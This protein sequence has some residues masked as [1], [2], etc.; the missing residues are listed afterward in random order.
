MN[1]RNPYQPPGAPVEDIVTLSGSEPPFFAVGTGKLLLMVIATSNLYSLYW[2]YR[3]WKTVERHEAQR[4]FP[5]LRTFLGALVL[6]PLFRRIAD[7]QRACKL[8]P[9]LMA[10][11]WAVALLVTTMI[12]FFVLPPWSLI[13]VLQIVPLLVAQAAANQVNAELAP[14]HDRNRRFTPLN[15]LAI[16]MLFPFLLALMTSAVKTVSG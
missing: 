8:R 10:K 6:Y 11:M 7:R 9:P 12:P 1:D 16:V 3:H 5:L 2:M 13:A 15:W 14:Q 4:I